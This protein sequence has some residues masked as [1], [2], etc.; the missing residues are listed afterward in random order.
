M[1]ISLGARGFFLDN[2]DALL[3]LRAELHNK[4]LKFERNPG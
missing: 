3:T 2:F 4:Q 1:A